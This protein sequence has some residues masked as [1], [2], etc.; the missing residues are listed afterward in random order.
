MNTP[1]LVGNDINI[2]NYQSYHWRQGLRNTVMP[3][4][5]LLNA[6]AD[7]S[8]ACLRTMSLLSADAKAWRDF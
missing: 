1:Q 3:R 4:Q 7:L 8:R 2:S 6:L 5:G